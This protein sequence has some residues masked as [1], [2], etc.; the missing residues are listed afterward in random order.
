MVFLKISRRPMAAAV[1]A[2]MVWGVSFFL[3]FFWEM[4]QV[5]FF[6]GMARSASLGRS[7]ALYTCDPRRREYSLWRLHDGGMCIPGLVLGVK[8]LEP[9]DSVGLSQCRAGRNDRF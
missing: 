5:P 9:V 1:L 6:L 4:A 2:L 8:T 7:L 3:H